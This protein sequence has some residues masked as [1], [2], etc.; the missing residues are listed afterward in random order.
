MSSQIESDR[1]LTLDNEQIIELL[2]KAEVSET[3]VPKDPEVDKPYVLKKI[4]NDYKIDPWVWAIGP[5]NKLK[6]NLLKNYS[7]IQ[8]G[9]DGKKKVRDNGFS[10]I[11]FMKEGSKNVVVIYKGDK[12]LGKLRAHGNSKNR[13]PF[14]R[15]S[16]ST[17]ESLKNQTHE[18][19]VLK[20]YED[21]KKD[22]M[23]G[24]PDSM[25]TESKAKFLLHHLPR[26]S[27]QVKNCRA[28]VSS[29]NI[30]SHDDIYACYVLSK[31]ELADEVFKLELVPDLMVMLGNPNI[32]NFVNRLLV[33]SCV[34]KQIISYDTTFNLC[35]YYVSI[36]CARNTEL[37]GD[38]I[39][40]VCFLI[41]EKKHEGVHSTFW[42]TFVKAKININSKV[43]IIT[44]REKSITNA[45]SS[46]GFESNH[47]YCYN[48]FIADVKYWLS[49]TNAPKKDIILY[50]GMIE[51]L[52]LTNSEEEFE[53]L[54]QSYKK[55]MS[56][57]F[58]DYFEK[59]LE[60]DI[61]AKGATFN[62]VR[63]P[64]FVSGEVNITNN[65]SEAL[66]N[67]LKSYQCGKKKKLPELMVDL[68]QFQYAILS[69]FN[70]ALEGV[71]NYKLKEKYFGKVEKIEH[72]TNLPTS[73]VADILAV[74]KEAG[75]IPQNSGAHEETVKKL[76][77]QAK[78]D[79]S[80]EMNVFTV[81][82]PVSGRCQC[83]EIRDFKFYCSCQ[84]G[85][86]CFHIYAVAIHIGLGHQ[87]V[88]NTPYRMVKIERKNCRTG[89]K[90]K[91]RKEDKV[92]PYLSAPDSELTVKHEEVRNS[93]E[94]EDTLD[95]ELT[96]GN[97]SK[98][99]AKTKKNGEL[100]EKQ[101]K[102]EDCS[103]FGVIF[104][105]ELTSC[106]SNE[107]TA[108]D[109]ELISKP[110]DSADCID[111]NE[112]PAGELTSCISNRN[113]AKDG[114]LTEKEGCILE[115]EIPNEA[116]Y[117][118]R[119]VPKKF[120]IENI[121][122]TCLHGT[123]L[124]TDKIINDFLIHYTNI[125][126]AN[127]AIF[128]MDPI[129]FSAVS[130]VKKITTKSSLINHLHKNEALNK[131]LL[132][133]PINQGTNHWILGVIAW[134]SRELIIFDSYS[135]YPSYA[136]EFLS[137]LK[138]AALSYTLAGLTFNPK[139]WSYSK[140]SDAQKQPN[141]FDCGLYLMFH[142]ASI[143]RKRELTVISSESGRNWIKYVLSKAP[144]PI[145]RKEK[146]NKV[147]SIMAQFANIC[148]SQVSELTVQV[149]DK[150]C[151]ETLIESLY[152]EKQYEKC[153]NIVCSFPTH[154]K[155]ESCLCIYCRK[156]YHRHCCPKNFKVY[157]I[158][159]NCEKFTLINKKSK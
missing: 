19:S 2:E 108:R 101:P 127:E 159:N 86:K 18:A 67:M 113:T 103:D 73:T 83:V 104:D 88:E 79:Y 46:S 148:L 81:K 134:K 60:R 14:I 93:S 130:S 42:N 25:D 97:S 53:N 102:S 139:E 22:V 111:F 110:K 61:K 126:R 37:I 49:K 48:H 136:N 105:S 153:S 5:T 125:W 55:T 75:C 124:I 99:N 64:A 120:K 12:S 141:G 10:R 137:L 84:S 140:A 35:D 152:H 89:G 87:A 131:D 68:V 32:V 62:A 123:R 39:F 34:E 76:A 43:P 26:N 1:E 56:S 91:P 133:V 33:Q 51:N 13:Q 44:D 92:I 132:L 30:L 74:V 71:G 121:N 95:H 15:I 6:N 151:F 45:V 63:Y 9:R 59:K 149:Q 106:I 100:T 50:R 31:T 116:L 11:I 72:N 65:I 109:G 158:C 27:R 4:S 150:I 90:K 129:M 40:P 57:L 117:T 147:T 94:S 85:A 66:N 138:I 16:K 23:A 96:F 146:Q 77:E 82:G 80:S 78:V 21:C 7:Y 114:E 144:F 70:R 128:I 112:V 156:W 142:A 36:L 17:I 155:S 118:E 20:Q 157:F 98:S 122:V 145:T 52:L 143:I 107:N 24:I 58:K 3:M 47:L 135:C 54:C 29:R 69:E 115:I 38:P 119:K 41:H 8:T 28:V 154:Q